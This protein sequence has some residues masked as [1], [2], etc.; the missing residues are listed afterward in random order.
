[1]TKGTTI[2]AVK[3]GGQVAIAGDGQIT[4]GDVIFKHTAKKVRTLFHDQIIAGFAGSVA[5]ALT[6]FERFESQLEKHSGQLKR[7]AVELAKEWRTDRVLRR[8]EAWLVVADRTEILVVSGEGDV[9]EPDEDLVAVGSG[10]GYAQAAAQALLRHSQLSAEEI[11]RT[12]LGIAAGICIYTNNNITVVTLGEG[13]K[14]GVVS[15]E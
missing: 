1:M 3:R 13:G 6:L 11:A 14:G 2:L 8:L 7:S 15:S 5:D 9:V 4:V 12:S 10:G